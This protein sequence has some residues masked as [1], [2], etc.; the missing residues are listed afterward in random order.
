[1]QEIT[2][3]FAS[4]WMGGY[5]CTDQ[6]NT[7]GDRVDFLH[8]TGHLDRIR[9]DY[10]LL[11]RFGIKTVREG[12]RWSRVE[13][14]PYEYDFRTLGIMLE[15]GR[16]CGIQQV[17]DLCHFGY[18]DDLSPLHPHFTR[19]F[20]ALCR[21]FATY[22]A[23]LLPH[24]TLIVTPINEVSFMSWLG[25][26]VAGTSPYCRHNGWEVKYALMRAYIAGIRALREINP[27]IRILTT[28]PL[29]NVVPTFDATDEQIAEA[30]HHH[31]LQYQSLD[32]LCGRICPELGGT[33]D[34]MDMLGFNFYYDNQ[35]ELGTNHTLHWNDLVPDERWRTLDDLL[36]EAHRRYNLPVVLSET[37]HPGI[38]R[39]IWI[40]RIAQECHR[41]IRLGVPL[42]GVCLYPIIDRPNW[43]NPDDWHEAGLW[44]IDDPGGQKDRILHEPSALAL[45][46]AQ[47][48]TADAIGNAG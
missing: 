47:Q 5:E 37:S 26:D 8:L 45:R 43:D 6:L 9:D 23:T 41:A 25:G 27:G 17:W 18:P 29:V 48:V 14:R 16:D 31:D 46:M 20:E 34:C 40:E 19:R 7:H 42:W 4:F 2:N 28:E 38:D 15:A 39:P 44:D 35:W 12:L 30:A 32:I 10:A 1:M 21:A 11:D 24:E 22:H 36:G 13:L 3:P 33:P